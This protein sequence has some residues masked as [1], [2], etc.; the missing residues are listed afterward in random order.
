MMQ[1]KVAAQTTDE[2]E[3]ARHFRM[4]P[5]VNESRWKRAISWTFHI[6]EHYR[7]HFQVTDYS[8]YIYA[9]SSFTIS[10]VFDQKWNEN[11]MKSNAMNDSLLK[12]EVVIDCTHIRLN[13]WT[14]WDQTRTRKDT[15]TA[16]SKYRQNHNNNNWTQKQLKDYH[17]KQRC[18]D[19]QFFRA[20]IHGY[21]CVCVCL[22]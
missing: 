19:A 21:V 10:I 11:A 6:V 12:M 4:C 13:C 15:H 16:H 14:R 8:M 2:H 9:W 17:T 7:T 3:C 18:H 5:N 1:Q 20:H 22:C